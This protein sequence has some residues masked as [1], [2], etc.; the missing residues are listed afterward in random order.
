MELLDAVES[1]PAH[2]RRQW[3]GLTERTLDIGF[4]EA[5]GAFWSCWTIDARLAS[6][7][8]SAGFSWR[9]IIYRANV[10]I[11]AWANS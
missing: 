9:M 5:G 10:D 11:P 8:A 3:D 2:L 7:A 6:R 4:S 1:L